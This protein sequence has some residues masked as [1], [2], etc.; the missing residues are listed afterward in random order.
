MLDRMAKA[1]SEDF[2][3]KVM[4]AAELGNLHHTLVQNSAAVHQKP[5][6][7]AQSKLAASGLG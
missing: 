1:Y 3:R 6:D 4:Q 2:R 7:S 5:C